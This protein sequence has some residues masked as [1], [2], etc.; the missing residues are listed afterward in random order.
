[1]D[2]T[3]CPS[4]LMAISLD[5]P[6]LPGAQM[7]CEYCETELRVVSLQPLR[8]SCRFTPDQRKIKAV[9]HGDEFGEDHLF[10]KF[11]PFP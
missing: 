4:C 8:L 9:H 2:F 3:Q 11:W 6:T 7:R 5:Q 10:S 1:M